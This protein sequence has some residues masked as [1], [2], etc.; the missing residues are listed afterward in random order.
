MIVLDS[1]DPVNVS[2]RNK[3][4]LSGIGVTLTATT[5]AG[6]AAASTSTTTAC[7][8]GELL[9]WGTS[10]RQLL[11]SLGGHLKM[12]YTVKVGKLHAVDQNGIPSSI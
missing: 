1:S 12:H 11:A 9:S 4:L 8:G 2:L 5:T 3:P 10:V 7:D 6:P